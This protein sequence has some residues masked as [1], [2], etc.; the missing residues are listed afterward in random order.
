MGTYNAFVCGNLPF[1]KVLLGWLELGALRKKMQ[2]LPLAAW[3]P[4]YGCTAPHI[5]IVSTTSSAK[6]D[7][8]LACLPRCAP[9][10][11]SMILSS[12]C[13]PT[14]F[15]N[16][17]RLSVL[18]HSSAD[19]LTTSRGVELFPAFWHCV[20]TCDTPQ[21]KPQTLGTSQ[22]A[23]TETLCCFNI[24]ILQQKNCMYL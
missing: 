15:T 14:L 4:N 18:Q 1:K 6:L 3:D 19:T 21:K 11:Q 7:G 12:D 8:N 24:F 13:G 10:R 2:H 5:W 20:T 23:P 16:S 22:H 17:S 9:S